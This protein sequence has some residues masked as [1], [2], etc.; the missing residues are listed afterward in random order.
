[1]G[2]VLGPFPITQQ[3]SMLPQNKLVDLRSTTDYLAPK[4]ET[5]LKDLHK[6]VGHLNFAYS[7][8]A[9]GRAFSG[10][11]LLP[12]RTRVTQGMSKDLLVGV[13]SLRNLM[14]SPS[15]IRCESEI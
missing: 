3:I 8:V 2:Q 6:L 13:N 1:M 10:A 11:Y 14:G 5:A 4:R 9:P 7:V 12:C 15:G